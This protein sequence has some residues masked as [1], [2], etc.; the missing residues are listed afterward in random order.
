MLRGR[1]RAL[2]PGTY[3]LRSGQSYGAILRDLTEGRGL[4]HTVTVPEGFALSTILPLLSRTLE[5]S[6]DSLD[7]VVRDS[8]LRAELGVPTRTLEGYLFPDTY[9]FPAG[10]SA[11]D[12]V[13]AMVRRFEQAWLPEWDARLAELGTTRHEIVTLASIV[14]KEA[15]LAEERPVIAAVYRN[16]LRIGMALQADPTVQYALGR[17]TARV[18]YKDLEIDSPYNTYKYPGLPPGPIAS[19][20]AASLEAT[21]YP[22]DVRYLYFVA[23]PDGHHEFRETFGQHE[24]AVVAMRRERARQEAEARRE[25]ERRGTPRDRSGGSR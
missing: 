18:L 6:R 4:V 20:G 9:S 21:L 5:L 1:D 16:R 17:H 12:V 24:Q 7:A 19:P 10:T 23:H 13:R 3:V 14:E 22:A 25:G 15:R 8:A 11:R 2:M